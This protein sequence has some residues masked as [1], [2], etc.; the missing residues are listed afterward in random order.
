M[1]SLSIAAVSP[2]RHCSACRVRRAGSLG[3]CGSAASARCLPAAALFLRA[4]RIDFVVGFRGLDRPFSTL[5]VFVIGFGF[6]AWDATETSV[7]ASNIQIV[8]GPNETCLF[9]SGSFV[10]GVVGSGCCGAGVDFVGDSV[11]C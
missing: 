1:L 11:G 3:D 9:L 2:V 6:R 4:M 8:G 7:S 10:V 5:A